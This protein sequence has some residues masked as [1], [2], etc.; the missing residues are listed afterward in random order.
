MGDAD[1]ILHVVDGSHPDPES[2]IAAVREVISEIDGARDI[3]EVIV[4]NKAD[5]ADP[6]T[7]ARLTM[8]ERHSIVVSARTGQGITELLELIERELPHLSHEVH[9]LVPYDRGDLIA[10]AHKEG[11]VLSIEHTGDGT[12]LQARG[13]GGVFSEL[14]RGGEAGA[15]SDLHRVRKP[16]E[17]LDRTS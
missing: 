10:R 8:R 13:V 12:V 17:T 9:M 5:A 3:P 6:V 15:F 2:Q 1:L 14:A 11:E 16:V 4:I 7:L